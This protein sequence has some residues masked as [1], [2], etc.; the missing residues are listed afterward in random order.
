[1]VGLTT[2]K[3]IEL[4]ILVLECAT[5]TMVWRG[6]ITSIKEAS[7][8]PVDGGTN[9]IRSCAGGW[10]S[11]SSRLWTLAQHGLSCAAHTNGRYV[12]ELR[13][14]DWVEHRQHLRNS[15]RFLRLYPQL[16]RWFHPPMRLLQIVSIVI[17]YHDCR[18]LLSPGGFW[19]TYPVFNDT[20]NFSDGDGNVTRG[21]DIASPV[22]DHITLLIWQVSNSS[23][24][25]QHCARWYLKCDLIHAQRT[26]N[27]LEV[28][29]FTT[30]QLVFTLA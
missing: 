29:A 22:V 3:S 15:S 18:C 5:D 2:N 12:V 14:V 26:Y 20:T 1:M 11:Q 19:Q 4:V 24:A 17:A 23:D 7:L 16:H 10:I 13:L 30:F 27:G 25:L 8:H 9:C 6:L 21:R 28:S